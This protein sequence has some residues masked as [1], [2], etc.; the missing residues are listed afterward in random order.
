MGK[1]MFREAESATVLRLAALQGKVLAMGGGVVLR[2]ET[3]TKVHRTGMIIFS[4]RALGTS[5][6]MWIRLPDR[7]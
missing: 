7:Y 4:D 1:I 6:R 2:P 5:L 3:H